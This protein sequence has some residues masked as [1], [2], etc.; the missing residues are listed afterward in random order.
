MLHQGVRSNL[1]LLTRPVGGGE[2]ERALIVAAGRDI[3][4]PQKH[5]RRLSAPTKPLHERRFEVAGVTPIP[6]DRS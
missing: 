1:S 2:G 4:G 3:R 5:D 6:H